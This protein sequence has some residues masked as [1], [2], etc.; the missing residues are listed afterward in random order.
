MSIDTKKITELE[1]PEDMQALVVGDVIRGELRDGYKGTLVCVG[2]A[3]SPTEHLQMIVRE[4]TNVVYFLNSGHITVKEGGA[5]QTRPC[6]RY[7]RG[8]E[9]ELFETIDGRLFVE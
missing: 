2:P 3:P 9:P 1:S 6:F 4:A 7:E 8:A 5:I